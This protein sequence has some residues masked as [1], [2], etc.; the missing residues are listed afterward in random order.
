M[1]KL[2]LTALA[3]ATTLGAAAWWH[4]KD[5]SPSIAKTYELM[6]DFATEGYNDA[7]SEM[8][9]DCYP[10]GE[11]VFTRRL[12]V[13]LKE[14]PADSALI[15]PALATAIK[16]FDKMLASL[17]ASS[18]IRKVSTD[19]DGN[20]TRAYAKSSFE[21]AMSFD[22]AIGL[23]ATGTTEGAMLKVNDGNIEMAQTF[24]VKTDWPLISD[25]IPL[26]VK[27]DEIS[28]ELRAQYPNGDYRM[29]KFE[30]E[31]RNSGVIRLRDT[32]ANSDEMTMG[33]AWEVS[34]GRDGY[35][36]W[37]EVSSKMLALVGEDYDMSLTY[38]R[39]R[40]LVTLQGNRSK[41][42]MAACYKDNTCYIFVGGYIGK[43]P[44]LPSNWMHAVRGN[45]SYY[46]SE[47]VSIDKIEGEELK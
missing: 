29:V 33:M 38:V 4:P 7:V 40:R 25:S 46:N 34:G 35:F 17:P 28:N 3:A 5:T 22:G 27:M 10:S 20:I 26:G 16:D 47:E 39:N 43:Q 44:F 21:S 32:Y 31:P 18:K 14:H 2:I 45:V 23:G 8:T 42:L 15:K 19:V 30:A 1:K 11:K 24:R 36:A 41:T 13:D 9:Y 6:A 37:E 12:Q